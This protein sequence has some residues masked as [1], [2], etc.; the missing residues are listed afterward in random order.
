MLTHVG[1]VGSD[2][3]QYLYLD[4]GRLLQRS[5]SMWDPGVGLGTVTHQNIGYLF[6]MGPYYWIMDRVGVPDWIALRI[7]VGSII[8]LAGLGVRRLLR[9]LNWQARGIGVASLAYALSPYL[10]H[11]VYKHSVI[12]LPFTALPWLLHFTSRS[13]REGGWRAPAWFALVCLAAGGVN[14]TSLLLVLIAPALWVL[15]AVFVERDVTLRDAI[16]P[17]LRISFLGV[18]TSLWWVAGLMVQGRYGFD[19]LR[20]TETYQTVSNASSAPEVLRGLGYWF[21]YGTDALGPWFRSAVTMTENPIAVPLSFAVPILAILAVLWTRWRTRMFWIALALSGLILSVGAFPFDSPSPYGS[22]FES[23]TR[24]SSGLAMRSTPR[25]I[26]LLAL[27]CAVFL[28]AGVD[29]A[30]RFLGTKRPALRR[31]PAIAMSLL[32]VANMSPLWTGNLQDATLER[33]GD[34]PQYWY[35]VAAQ[36]DRSGNDTRVLEV[37]GSEFAAYRWGNTVDPVT[38]GLMSRPY[39]A[40]EL[41]PWG[42]TASANLMNA[43]DT[44]LQNASYDPAGMSTMLRL[45]GVGDLVTRNDLEYERYRTPRPRLMSGWFDRTFGLGAPQGFGPITHNRAIATHPLIDDVELTIDP[46]A[47]NPRPVEIRS[48]TDPADIVRSLPAAQ[49]VIVAGDGAGLVGM[50]NVGRLPLDAPILYSGSVSNR[51]DEVDRLL[52]D[53][54]RLVV[55]DTNR[56]AAYRWGSSRDNTGYTET[57]DEQPPTFDPT[58]NRLPPFDRPDDTSVQTVMVPRGNWWARSSDYGNR[59]SYTPGDRAASVLDGDPFTSWKTRAFADPRGQWI[60]LMSLKGPVTRNHVRLNQATNFAN[61]YITRARLTFDGKDPMEISLPPGNAVGIQDIAFGDRTFSTLRIT[62]LATDT[63]V[64]NNYR[65]LSGVGFAEVELDDVRTTEMIRPP[66]DLLAAVGTRAAEH[67]V[68]WVFNRRRSN[69]AEPVVRS[70]E[71]ALRRIVT[72]PTARDAAV[73]ARIRLSALRS[74]AQ[75]DQILGRDTRGGTTASSYRVYGDTRHRASEAFD[76]DPQTYWQSGLNHKEPWLEWTAPAPTT[77]RLGDMV[78]LDDPNH[79]VPTSARI[80]VDGQFGPTVQLTRIPAGA[81]KVKLSPEGGPQSITGTRIRIVFDHLDQRTQPEWLTSSPMGMPVAIADVLSAADGSPL[82]GPTPSRF[83]LKCSGGLLKIGDTDVALRSEEVSTEDVYN[84][85][86]FAATSAGCGTDAVKLAAGDNDLVAT[87]GAQSGIDVDT[88]LLHS[89]RSGEPVTPA[90]LDKPAV[91]TPSS[92]VSDVKIDTTQI[93]GQLLPD[94]TDR[95]LVLGQS[96]NAGWRLEVGGKDLG[97]SQLVN[98]Y[99][100]GWRIPA[101]MLRDGATF[102]MVWEPQRLVW[103]ALGLSLLGAL[104]CVALAFGAPR[105]TPSPAPPISVQAIRWNDDF[106]NAVAV[107]PAVLISLVALLGGVASVRGWWAGPL[108]GLVT[109]AAL[110][111][112]RGWPA[113]RMAAPALVTAGVVYVLI[114]E[115]LARLHVD[116]DWPQQFEPAHPLVMVGM[117]LIGVE[118]AVEAIRGGWRRNTGLDR[119]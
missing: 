33:A 119:N 31:V 118:A 51:P 77:V 94:T 37:P 55:T 111:V 79:S 64:L 66:T 53:D 21:F 75:L 57:A 54:A 63:G 91:P 101:G 83:N 106:G 61:R 11:Y 76:G 109:F 12:L 59:L 115:L 46:A 105:R 40:R 24:T 86:P 7:W 4:P 26:P 73:S 103:W 44:P 95:W 5:L 42:S 90:G 50:A 35:D 96:N 30:A 99:A 107:R 27:A 32:V 10:L 6:P 110:R 17:I 22:L 88:L 117:L 113:L 20:V 78:A 39:A 102:R 89:P 58:D 108:I 14:A 9:T 87:D 45:M 81:G 18:I 69:P 80:E 15:H 43:V 82:V 93:T 104:V 34:I 2:T 60:E 16:P 62:V 47:R 8:L 25:A 29:V 114:H 67:S 92:A 74:D 41:V 98:G 100:N 65:G 28:A 3:K 52:A 19:I 1:K 70:E 38:P 13:L 49:P 72:T 97:E 56:K 23:F 68:D 84:G 48:V 36:L 71:L 112:R 116:F 85:A